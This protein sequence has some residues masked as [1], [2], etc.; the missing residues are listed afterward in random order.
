MFVKMIFYYFFRIS[1]EISMVAI[2]GKDLKMPKSRNFL[3][4]YCHHAVLCTN[5]TCKTADE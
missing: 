3:S 5:A 2:I 1:L 4:I